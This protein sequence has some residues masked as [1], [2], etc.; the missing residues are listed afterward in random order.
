LSAHHDPGD[1][2][3]V[4]ATLAQLAGGALDPVELERDAASAASLLALLATLWELPVD[5]VPP[6]GAFSAEWPD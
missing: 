4:P 6:A 2:P 5:G 3:D 1:H